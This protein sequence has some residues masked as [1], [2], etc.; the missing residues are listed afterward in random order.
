VTDISVEWVDEVPERLFRGSPYDEVAEG[1][2]ESGR[3]AKLPTSKGS[4]HTLANR[5]RHRYKDLGVQGRTTA[6]GHYVYIF[7]MTDAQKAERTNARV[8][9]TQRA[10]E[11]AKER[12]AAKAAEKKA[13]KEKESK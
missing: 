1:V 6:D 9:A 5:L 8:L 11:R 10:A 7:V 4:L 13:A 12:K 3:V 2:R